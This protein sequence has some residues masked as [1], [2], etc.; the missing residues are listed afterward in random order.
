[1]DL[2]IFGLLIL[3][4]CGINCNAQIIQGKFADKQAD[5]LRT[6]GQQSFFPGGDKELI[7]EKPGRFGFITHIPDDAL[8]IIGAPFKKKNLIPIFITAGTTALLVL[9]DKKVSGDVRQFSDRIGLH[10]E[11][12]Y[13]E[14]WNINAGKT[15]ISLLKAPQNINTALYQMGQ[16]FPGLLIGVGIFGYG[17]LHHNFR[18]IS[19]ANQLAE[20]FILMGVFTQALKRISGRRSPFLADNFRDSWKPFPSFT[21]YQK[22]T[23]FYD[24]FPSGHLATL[25]SSVTVLSENYPEK[26]WIKPIG[27]SL[28]GLV[29]YAMINNSVHW[30]SDYPLALVLGYLCGK[31]VAKTNRKLFRTSTHK[32]N[33]KLSYTCTYS[34]GKLLPGIRLQF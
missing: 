30:I 28:T 32:K 15:K 14:L 6:V 33:N 27:Y 23:P 2:K 19:T 16:G 24:A 29:G 17:K 25:M 12:R 11:E 20:S 10:R 22:N 1:M 8:A 34:E 9:A 13:T 21:N 26:K 18:A 7:Y 4:Y 31:Q 5:S 3:L